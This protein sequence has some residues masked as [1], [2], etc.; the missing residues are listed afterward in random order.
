M[1]NFKRDAVRILF[2]AGL[3]FNL[4][5]CSTFST[6]KNLKKLILGSWVLD[7]VSAPREIL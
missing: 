5:N 6:E 3:S 2:I 4:L 7:S 1:N